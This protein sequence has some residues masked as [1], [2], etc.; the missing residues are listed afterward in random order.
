[1]IKVDLCSTKPK[2]ISTTLVPPLFSA[3][4]PQPNITKTLNFQIQGASEWLQQTSPTTSMPVSKHSTPG[5]KPPSVALGPPPPTGIEDLLSLEQADS[6]APKLMAT[7]SQVSQHVATPNDILATIP[8][9]HSPSPPPASKTLTAAN[10]LSAPQ[11]Q[12]HPRA[13]P[14]TLSEEVL[15]LQREMNTAR[16]GC[17]ELGPPWTSAIEG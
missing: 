5:R 13:D 10:I 8:I 6:D 17:S 16:G 2:A 4:K 7:S 15:H 12:T 3:I 1:M 14:N 9:S 11:S